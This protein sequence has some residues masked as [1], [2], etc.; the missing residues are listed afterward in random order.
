[1]GSNCHSLY[2]RIV[3]LELEHFVPSGFDVLVLIRDVHIKD[4]FQIVS[5][6]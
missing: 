4:R 3:L 6:V 1:M 2:R 5:L